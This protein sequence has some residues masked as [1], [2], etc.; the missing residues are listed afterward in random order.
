MYGFY[1]ITCIFVFCFLRNYLVRIRTLTCPN[2]ALQD[3]FIPALQKRADNTLAQLHAIACN[4][5]T[6]SAWTI[7]LNGGFHFFLNFVTVLFSWV[8]GRLQFVEIGEFTVPYNCCVMQYLYLLD[9]TQFISRFELNLGHG[10]YSVP[11]LACTTYIIVI[12]Y[13]QTET[14]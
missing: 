9:F 13:H 1:I 8:A 6:N 4:G 11:V 7:F 12:T 14:V 5:F 2:E 3:Q 10:M